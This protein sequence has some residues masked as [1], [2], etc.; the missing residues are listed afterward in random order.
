M[1]WMHH[2][3]SSLNAPSNRSTLPRMA[4]AAHAREQAVL[5]LIQLRRVVRAI[6]VGDV[7]RGV[8]QVALG[9]QVGH[10]LSESKTIG[11]GMQFI[12]KQ[13]ELGT[14]GSVTNYSC[15]NQAS[16]FD[17][18]NRYWHCVAGANLHPSQIAGG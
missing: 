17:W 14:F 6:E 11:Q 1:A 2:F 9:W 18:R 3:T 4:L 10:G 16:Y 15:V 7:V 5:R 8:E 12:E 13:F